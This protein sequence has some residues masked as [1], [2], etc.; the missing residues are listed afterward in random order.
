MKKGFK[1]KFVSA[2]L[3]AIM[4]VSALTGTIMSAN[5]A[6]RKN[7]YV[8]GDANGDRVVDIVDVTIA[9]GYINGECFWSKTD[10]ANYSL[11][12]NDDGTIDI[13]D[14]TMILN[15]INGIKPLRR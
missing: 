2:A 12:V 1:N 3:A 9:I 4:S 7:T 14:V 15:H 5:A 11:D 13:E 8:L 6:G 10:M